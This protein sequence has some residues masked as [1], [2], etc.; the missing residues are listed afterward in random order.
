MKLFKILKYTHINKN[1]NENVPIDI[2]MY[3]PGVNSGAYDKAL[4]IVMKG[5]VSVKRFFKI[6]KQKV[7]LHVTLPAFMVEKLRNECNQILELEH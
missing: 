1:W 5:T 6:K 4:V 2:E 3:V 7:Y